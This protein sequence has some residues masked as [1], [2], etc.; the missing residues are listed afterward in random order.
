M[1]EAQDDQD[2]FAA[3]IVGFG[4]GGAALAALL[5]RGGHRVVVLEK[6][7]RPYGLPRMS[8]LDGEIA[9]LLQHTGDAKVALK[10]AIPQLEVEMYGADGSMIATMDWSNRRSGHPSHLS[11]HQP[12][13]E[14]AMADRIAEFAHVDVRWGHTV[15]DFSADCAGFSIV[16]ATPDGGLETVQARYLIG[17]DGASS[18]VREILGIPLDVVHEHT[19]RWVL[20]DYEIV[21]PL[22]QDLGR[23]IYMY[24]DIET[25]YFYGPNGAGRCRTDVRISEDAPLGDAQIAADADAGF[26]FLEQHVGISRQHVR[27]TRRVVYRFRSHIAQ[28]LRV[29][30]AFIGGDAAHAMPPHMGQG[31]CT[32]MRDA[33]NLGWKLDLVLR[34]I[35]DAELLETYESERLDHDSQFVYASLGAWT[36]ATQTDAE[37]AAQRDEFMRTTNESLD[38]YIEPLRDGILH[39]N[40]HDG[41]GRQAGELAPQGRVRVGDREAL[42]DDIVGY[43]FQLVSTYHLDQALGPDRMERL[44]RL[45]VHRVV[46]GEGPGR[47]T[48]I[49]GTYTEFFTQNTAV[50]FIGR[51]DFYIFGVA[52]TDADAAELVDC[53]IAQLKLRTTAAASI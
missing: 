20:T 10:G 46:I 37:S 7:P 51:P 45:G 28:S 4:P 11:V 17:M 52:A 9:R 50:A 44:D 30:D 26:D 5:G 18:T 39:R 33:A 1:A 40:S 6:A 27:Q 35:A 3:A 15:T 29:G 49:E 19:D 31:A 13:I 2:R 24:M 22:P 38:M 32:A 25:P 14:A 8:T 53:L 41:Y 42:L 23:R 16:A 34:G 12:N 43:G 36:M 21:E 47:Y 48:D